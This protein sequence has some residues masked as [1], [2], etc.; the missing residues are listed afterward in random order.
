MSSNG[1]D[2]D[3]S[4]DTEVGKQ[5]AELMNRRFP[6][7]L[8]D[9]VN[10][11]A[12]R[13]FMELLTTAGGGR[14]GRQLDEIAL[15]I[16]VKKVKALAAGTAGPSEPLAY[17]SL[18]E[19]CV[20]FLFPVYACNLYSTAIKWCPSWSEHTGAV[21]R[22]EAAWRSFEHYRLEGKPGV[23]NWLVS[24]G[25]PLMAKL[26]DPDTGPFA[27][28]DA[29]KGHEHNGQD[30]IEDLPHTPLPADSPYARKTPAQPVPVGGT[31]GAGN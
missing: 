21:V 2:D 16:A 6:P 1:F 11:L 28:C 9:V 20:E 19:F 23:A 29:V 5:I 22:L 3:L 8:R 4:L 15:R 25:D 7:N 24:V 17:A 31:S 30:Q 10:T 12:D 13:K 14:I 26:M 27:F 18:E